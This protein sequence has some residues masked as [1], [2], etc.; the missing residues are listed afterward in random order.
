ML[1]LYH[2]RQAVGAWLDSGLPL[3]TTRDHPWHRSPV[4]LC[5]FDGHRGAINDMAGHI[6]AWRA[7]H[8][9]Q[10]GGDENMIAE[11]LWSRIRESTLVHS[12]FGDLHGLGGFIR[13]FPAKGAEGLRF[14]GE[15][16]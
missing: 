6:D 15:R 16:I 3:Q 4:M 11:R 1:G 14:I 12:E 5:D 7:N 8:A 9:D 10:Y 13:P 2:E